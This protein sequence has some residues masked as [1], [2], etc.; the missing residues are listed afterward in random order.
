MNIVHSFVDWKSMMIILQLN[1]EEKKFYIQNGSN[2]D[3]NWEN[4]KFSNVTK[5][6]QHKFE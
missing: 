1:V 2:N 6:L 4:S 5:F 3:N